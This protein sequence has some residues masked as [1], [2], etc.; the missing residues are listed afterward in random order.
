MPG[1]RV[2][3]AGKWAPAHAFEEVQPG[4]CVLFVLADPADGAAGFGPS[5]RP[6]GPDGMGHVDVLPG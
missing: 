6:V 5:D 2:A 4:R 1:T 3:P